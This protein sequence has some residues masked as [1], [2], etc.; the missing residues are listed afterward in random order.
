[1][2]DPML[3]TPAELVELRRVQGEQLDYALAAFAVTKPPGAPTELEGGTGSE[4]PTA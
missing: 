3:L 1:M 2:T 4:P